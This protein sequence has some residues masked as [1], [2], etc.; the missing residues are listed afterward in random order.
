MLQI[1]EAWSRSIKLV[2]LAGQDEDSDRHPVERWLD[3]LYPAES[4]CR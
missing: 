1:T 3:V 2:T 4:S